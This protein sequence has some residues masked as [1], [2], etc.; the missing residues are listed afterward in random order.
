MSY[1]LA[2]EQAYREADPLG[3]DF[4]PVNP[5]QDRID[6]I[7]AILKRAERTIASPRYGFYFEKFPDST[8]LLKQQIGWAREHIAR[9]GQ[10]EPD[11]EWTLE[12]AEFF[13]KVIDDDIDLAIDRVDD[14]ASDPLP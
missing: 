13:A 8:A 2:A 1:E 10:V 12:T 4:A 5:N 14:W 3:L 7:E 9:D 6:K 11:G